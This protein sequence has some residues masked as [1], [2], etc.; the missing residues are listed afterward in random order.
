MGPSDRVGLVSVQGCGGGQPRRHHPDKQA[1]I[2]A[3]PGDALITASLCMVFLREGLAPGGL[4][5]SSI[6]PRGQICGR[7]SRPMTPTSGT[8]LLVRASFCIMLLNKF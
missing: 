4:P 5:Y 3:R 1:A 6:E 2:A 8:L 7:A